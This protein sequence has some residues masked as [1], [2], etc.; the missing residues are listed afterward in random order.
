MTKKIEE[1]MR[2][3]LDVCTDTITPEFFDLRN[4]F[5]PDICR[6]H[7]W[8]DITEI[9]YDNNPRPGRIVPVFHSGTLRRFRTFSNYDACRWDNFTQLFQCYGARP[10]YLRHCA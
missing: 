7:C 3:F 1:F 10:E 5:H 8:T 6:S 4:C 9:R 2:V